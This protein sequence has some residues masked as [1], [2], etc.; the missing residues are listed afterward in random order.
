[1]A[2]APPEMPPLDYESMEAPPE[3]EAAPARSAQPRSRDALRWELDSLSGLLRE[4]DLLYQINRILRELADSDTRLLNGP[5]ADFGPA[6]FRH[7]DHQALMRAFLESLEQD[8]Y[9]ILEYIFLHVDSV[10][11]RVLKEEILLDDVERL[12]P[13]LR[14]G[15]SVD[16][17][18][19]MRRADV[20]N[21]RAELLKN[22]LRLRRQRIES[23]RAELYFMMM[24][25]GGEAH[26]Q[27]RI[28]LSIL[29]KGKID[30]ELERQVNM[31]G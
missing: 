16:L 3:E 21:R 5:L 17:E 20:P 25:S 19:V 1:V 9:T 29:A 24:D 31:I 13:R 8:E 7:S 18:V 4:P 15:L 26:L 12:R 27:E 30:A 10:L 23:E 6:D 11:H 22:A 28:Y 14:H 2:D